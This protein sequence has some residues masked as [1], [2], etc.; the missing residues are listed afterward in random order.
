MKIT[1]YENLAD[2]MPKHFKQVYLGNE[3]E[4]YLIAGGFD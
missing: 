3:V 2:T 4:A 1:D